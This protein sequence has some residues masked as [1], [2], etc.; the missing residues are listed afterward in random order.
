MTRWNLKVILARLL[1]HCSQHPLLAVFLQHL[2]PVFVVWF[3]ALWTW[4]AVL[5]LLSTTFFYV[6]L[7][8]LHHKVLGFELPALPWRYFISDEK[9]IYR[10]I[11]N[12]SKYTRFIFEGFANFDKL[13]KCIPRLCSK[14]KFNAPQHRHCKTYEAHFRFKQN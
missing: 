14:V 4:T 11:Q 8:F 10:I 3:R 1:V 13:D 9:W 2:S 7:T 5:V 12:V 6:R